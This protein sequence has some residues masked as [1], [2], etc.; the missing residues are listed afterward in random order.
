MATP[1]RQ[2]VDLSSNIANLGSSLDKSV[3]LEAA[4][5]ETAV[6]V[7]FKCLF[8]LAVETCWKKTRFGNLANRAIQSGSMAEE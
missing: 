2:G 4:K 8:T 5:S 7:I 3:K 6:S 1:A